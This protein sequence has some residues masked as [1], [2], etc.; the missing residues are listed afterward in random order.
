MCKRCKPI[1]ILF[2]TSETG[3]VEFSVTYIQV[4]WIF[5]YLQEGPSMARAFVVIIL[6]KIKLCC[7]FEVSCI[8][9][10][11]SSNPN[12]LLHSLAF[13]KT[14]YPL[15]NNCKVHYGFYATYLEIQ[16]DMIKCVV[17]LK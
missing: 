4:L 1:K 17:Y 11:G 6:S 7:L 14:N 9:S 3:I 8:N 15:C 13:I 5:N 2:R 12:N 10:T 16:E